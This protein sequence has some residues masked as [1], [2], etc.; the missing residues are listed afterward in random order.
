M[1]LLHVVED[2]D[3]NLAKAD[4]AEQRV[5]EEVHKKD[6]QHLQNGQLIKIA[7]MNK[8]LLSKKSPLA[9]MPMINA[10]ASNLGDKN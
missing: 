6:I 1:Q 2:T 4:E 10:K 5:I 3:G 9:L 7:C 8:S